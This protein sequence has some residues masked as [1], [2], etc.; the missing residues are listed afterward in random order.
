MAGLREDRPPEFTN[1]ER[2]WTVFTRQSLLVFL[3]SSGIAIFICYLLSKIN[4]TP[5]GIVLGLLFVFVSVA[6]TILPLPG[7][8]VL[9]GAGL[10]M[11]AVVFQVAV[12]KKKRHLY[13]KLT[14]GRGDMADETD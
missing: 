1:D 3:I 2:W 7:N 14:E 8:D 13:I 12:R 6:M 10:L 9:R 4:L 5:V 11:W